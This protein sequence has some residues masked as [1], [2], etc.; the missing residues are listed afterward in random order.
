MSTGYLYYIL[1]NCCEDLIALYD[2]LM[3]IGE[4]MILDNYHPTE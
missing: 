1:E 2:K 4:V 3:N